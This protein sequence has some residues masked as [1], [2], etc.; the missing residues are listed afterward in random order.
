MLKEQ[1][2]ALQVR[3]FSGR[4]L[5]PAANWLLHSQSSKRHPQFQALLAIFPRKTWG[6]PKIGVPVF[7]IHFSRIFPFFYDPAVGV[8]LNL[9]TPI[10]I[11]EINPIG[12][13]TWPMTCLLVALVARFD[14]PRVGKKLLQAPS[15]RRAV[16]CFPIFCR[17]ESPILNLFAICDMRSIS[18]FHHLVMEHMCP[19]QNDVQRRRPW[20]NR[21][22]IRV[23][24]GKH[25]DQVHIVGNCSKPNPKK[26]WTS[27]CWIQFSTCTC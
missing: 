7:F 26:P 16:G 2:V 9:E 23:A 17:S 3:V 12:T 11:V 6:F 15:R 18:V 24:T 22:V 13:P 5:A 1:L 27:T 4:T 21:S 10:L 25:E 8:S 14:C 19:W 20:A